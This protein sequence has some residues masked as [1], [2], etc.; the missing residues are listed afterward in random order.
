ME[1]Q[2]LSVQGQQHKI[3]VRQW[4]ICPMQ[5]VMILLQSVIRRRQRKL[6]LSPLVSKQT[7]Q[8]FIP[9]LL[10]PQPKLPGR[11]VWPAVIMQK[12]LEA[13]QLLWVVARRLRSVALLHWVMVLSARPIILTQQLKM[14]HSKTIAVRR[15]MSAMQLLHPLKQA[16][17]L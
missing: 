3:T 16:R 14:P 7:V 12:R 2:P 6:I 1:M 11:I 4:A 17:F 9:P 10:V 13:I 8:A 5:S 15:L